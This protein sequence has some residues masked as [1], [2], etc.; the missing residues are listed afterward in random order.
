MTLDSDPLDLKE[1]FLV[2]PALNNTILDS[3]LDTRDRMGRLISFTV[4]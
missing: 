3:H 4:G 2:P 1:R